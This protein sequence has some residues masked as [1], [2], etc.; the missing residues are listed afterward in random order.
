METNWS[1]DEV[2]A[3]HRNLHTNVIYDDFPTVKFHLQ[4]QWENG[5]QITV[6]RRY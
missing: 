3:T 6:K 4:L 1:G 5:N 2:T